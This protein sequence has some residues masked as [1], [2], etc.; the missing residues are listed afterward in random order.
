MISMSYFYSFNNFFKILYLLNL[1][2]A[3]IC[4]DSDSLGTVER[5][6]DAQLQPACVFSQKFIKVHVLKL[7]PM[8]TKIIFF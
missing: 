3:R 5:M 2:L 7:I 1:R 8:K 6:K 4:F